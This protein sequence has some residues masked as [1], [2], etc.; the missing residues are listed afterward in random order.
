MEKPQTTCGITLIGRCIKDLAQDDKAFSPADFGSDEGCILDCS[1]R[2]FDWAGF[3]YDTNAETAKG[4]EKG[5]EDTANA[6]SEF[7]SFYASGAEG[8]A[9]YFLSLGRHNPKLAE[10]GRLAAEAIIDSGTVV[11]AIKLVTNREG[12]IEGDHQAS[13]WTNGTGTG[14]GIPLPSEHAAATMALARVIAGKYPRW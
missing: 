4:F 11:A 8:A 3:A 9:I 10:T 5:R 14:T 1:V 6:I 7:G 12:S 2:R 13:F